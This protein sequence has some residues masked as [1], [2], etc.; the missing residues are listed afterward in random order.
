MPCFSFSGILPRQCQSGTGLAKS[1]VFVIIELSTVRGWTT[2]FN[3]YGKREAYVAG[4][5]QER[6]GLGRDWAADTAGTRMAYL[7]NRTYLL[8][9]AIPQGDY[10]FKMTINGTWDESYG[11][12][13][14]QW[15]SNLAFS[16]DRNEEVAFVFY[17]GEEGRRVTA[18]HSGN[19]RDNLEQAHWS[20][21]DAL[22]AYDGDDLG[23]VYR[24]G[25]ATLK[26][27]APKA[28]KVVAHF[29]DKQDAT[30]PIGV[31]PMDR[32]EQGIWRVEAAPHQLGVADV[33]GCYYQYEVVHGDRARRVLDPYAKSMA[34]FRVSPKGLPVGKD[35]DVVGKAA[36]VDLSQTRP[37]RALAFADIAGYEKREDAIIYEAHVRDFTS[38]PSIAGLLHARWGTFKA[39]IE[40]L[41]Y[42]KSLGVTHIQLLP[43]M[44]W[45]Y[46]DEAAMGERE[47]HDSTTNNQY[48]WGYD[49]HGY[50]SPDGAYSE[51]PQDPEA[52]IR[53]LKEL[54]AAIHEAGMGVMLDVVYT[55][56]AKSWLLEDIVPGYYFYRRADGE[57]LGGF[58]NNLATNHRMAHKLMVDSVTYWFSEYQ[59]DGMRWDMMGDATY[60]SIQDAYDAAAAIHPQPLFIGEGWRTFSG[61]MA[62]PALAG[63]GADQDWMNKTDDVGVFSDE[64]RNELKSGF[65]SEGQPGSLT[66]GARH[67]Q[68]LFHNIKAQPNNVPADAPGDIVHYVEAHDNLTLHDVIAVT[69]K[70]DPMVRAHRQEIH[71]RIRLAH[72]LLCTSQGTLF[73]HAGQEYG[74]SKRWRGKG[75]PQSDSRALRDA[76]GQIMGYFVH[77]SYDSSDAIN[78]FDWQKVL[79]AARYP[80]CHETLAYVAGLIR[81][82][83]STNAFR[84]GSK[85]L[86][87]RHVTLI[88]EP[89]MRAYD[90]AIAYRCA[91]ADGTGVYYVFVNAG[92]ILRTWALQDDLMGGEVLVDGSRAGVEA[93]A[94][95][96]GIVLSKGAVTLE[97][98]TAA[99]IRVGQGR[100]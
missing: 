1:T 38:D 90:L 51:A 66:G 94:S 47:L 70:V 89:A 76:Q 17:D 80:N 33:R 91:S 52:R 23:A 9:L 65:G 73:L 84:L 30:R 57:L 82:R 56:M 27:W 2:I 7:G 3:S 100:V 61:Y 37:E 92:R 75:A 88:E 25:R 78:R 42:V 68:K 5:F 26:L 46:G 6:L 81:L 79:N 62:E 44:A 60:E 54:I 59:I 72:V 4:T 36:I 21:L 71:R 97:P 86:V 55:H 99:V 28:S 14:V 87:D 8:R 34:L 93:L 32:L 63:H 16:L 95:S 43:V 41:P 69:L 24:D 49:P 19:E 96:S 39:F 18:W 53:E 35:G 29:Y 48:N 20:E 58:G 13:G 77:N 85:Q 64:Y 11:T 31:L 50:F 67:I 12:G 74:R 45:Y 15:G 83:K 10:E 98:L 40:R 22:Y